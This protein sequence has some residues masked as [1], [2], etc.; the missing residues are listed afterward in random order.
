M[1]TL[2]VWKMCFLNIYTQCTHALCP[3]IQIN[4]S[5]PGKYMSETI[6]YYGIVYRRK[7]NWLE[8][9]LSHGKARQSEKLFYERSSVSKSFF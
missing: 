4:E 6:H 3:H 8:K 5:H 2:Y 9:A 1:C 7:L